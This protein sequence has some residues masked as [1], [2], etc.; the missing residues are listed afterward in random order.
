MEKL[1]DLIFLSKCISCGK[2][3]SVICGDCSL[4]AKVYENNECFICNKRSK[5]S[6][7]HKKC[8]DVNAPDYFSSM[9]IYDGVVREAIK[10]SKYYRKEFAALIYLTKYSISNLRYISNKIIENKPDAICPIPMFEAKLDERKFNTAFLIAKVLGKALNIPVITP[11][12]RV[13]PT[14]AQYSLNRIERFENLKNAFKVVA[15]EPI[16]NKHI[17]IAD[18]ICTTGAT[19][20]AS[21]NAL[22]AAGAA[23][24]GAFTLARK[25]LD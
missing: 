8:K 10:R 24:I 23:K 11:L 21:T 4:K 18:D 1:L 7:M 19:L 6:A 20:L 12:V 13:I 25:T 3:G 22:K 15:K 14:T 5:D 9:F 2:L 17:L 16:T